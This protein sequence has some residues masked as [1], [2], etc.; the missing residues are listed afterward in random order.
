[1]L[2]CSSTL[3]VIFDLFEVNWSVNV[4]GAK[5]LFNLIAGSRRCCFLKACINQGIELIKGCMQH[6]Q[7]IFVIRS[8]LKQS[9]GTIAYVTFWSLV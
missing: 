7:E 8:T 9:F 6:F 2:T 3:I 1:M 4:Y 5:L